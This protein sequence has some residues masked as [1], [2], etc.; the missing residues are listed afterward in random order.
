MRGTKR[1]VRWLRGAGLVL[2]ALCAAEGT[3][4][5]DTP[6]LLLEGYA[7]QAKAADP[8]FDGFS[9]ERGRSFYLSKHVMK[10]VGAV[11]CA[12]CHRKDPREQVKAHKVDILCRACHVI[13]DE[14]HPSPKRGEAA[15][16]RT[17]RTARQP[18][19]LQR[20]G[21]RRE[22][23]QAQLHDGAQ[24]RVHP[25]RE[26]RPDRLAADRGGRSAVPG[27]PR[28]RAGAR[29]RKRSSGRHRCGLQRLQGRHTSDGRRFAGRPIVVESI[30]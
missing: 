29:E 6:E 9:A 13:N 4:A 27:G 24:A 28:H 23:L 1:W 17:V 22:V 18:G 11:S 20:L 12:S 3:T 5:A 14:E 7:E 15:L 30:T 10:G 8:A 16:H 25:A 19:A 2:G 21:A 26:R